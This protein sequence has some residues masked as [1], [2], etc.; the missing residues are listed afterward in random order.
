MGRRSS[1]QDSP[2]QEVP[3]HSQ[4]SPVSNADVPVSV[5]VCL[6]SVFRLCGDHVRLLSGTNPERNHFLG[7]PPLR[8]RVLDHVRHRGY[9][10]DNRCHSDVDIYVCPHNMGVY[11]LGDAESRHQYQIWTVWLK[12]RLPHKHLLG[13]RGDRSHCLGGILR[14]ER[15][16]NST[17]DAPCTD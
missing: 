3:P 12:F 11:L 9:G 6:W 14:T 15:I 1:S 2:W 8:Y 5:G 17:G 10:S 4:V 16:R 7:L 13:S